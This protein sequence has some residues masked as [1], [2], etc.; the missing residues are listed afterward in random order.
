MKEAK[1]EEM[2]KKGGAASRS[3]DVVLV[4]DPFQVAHDAKEVVRGAT[5][6]V[7]DEAMAKHA[8]PWDPGHIESPAR[9]RRT[10]E[11]CGELGL[12]DRCLRL[13]TR[14]AGDGELRLVHSQG[15]L[16]AIQEI[17]RLPVEEMK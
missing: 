9:L 8:N 1:K 10:V 13:P 16:D 7:Y 6:V 11:R 5:G 17:T 2:K 15:H 14:T 12:L 3:A 4:S